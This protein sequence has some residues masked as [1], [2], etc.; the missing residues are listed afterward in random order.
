MFEKHKKLKLI[1][2]DKYKHFKTE[3][4]IAKVIKCQVVV[5]EWLARKKRSINVSMKSIPLISIIMKIIPYLT[6]RIKQ[7]HSLF[8]VPLIAE[9]WEETLHRSFMDLNYHTTWTPDR[10]HKVGEDMRIQSIRRSRISCKSGQFITPRDLKKKC[11]KINGGRSTKFETLEEKIKHFSGDH[12]DVYCCLA[13]SKP[14]DKKYTLL[15]FE[16]SLINVK[17]LDWKESRTG[18]EW[19]GKGNF[20]ATI[21]KSMSAQLWTIIPLDLIKYKFDIDCS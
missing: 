14:F 17:Q 19:Q 21:G 9:L 11:V 2:K 5:R 13:K 6:S 8:D 10:S 15:V 4:N 18:K 20:S 12:D 7:Y 16:S 3:D 1:I